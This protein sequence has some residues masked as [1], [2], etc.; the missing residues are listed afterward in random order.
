MEHWPDILNSMVYEARNGRVRMHKPNPPAK[1]LGSRFPFPSDA[2][3]FCFPERLTFEKCAHKQSTHA[4]MLL[5]KTEGK[6]LPWHVTA[7][8]DDDIQECSHIGVIQHE[9]LPHANVAL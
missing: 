1:K 3:N 7:I 2:K 4:Y 9:I 6:I 5:E 8:F